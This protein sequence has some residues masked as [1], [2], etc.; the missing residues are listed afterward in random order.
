MNRE[1]WEYLLRLIARSTLTA[2]AIARVLDRCSIEAELTA[3][4]I[5]ELI[6]DEEHS[7]ADDA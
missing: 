5:Q 3:T 7:R 4:R 1:L 6:A 2:A